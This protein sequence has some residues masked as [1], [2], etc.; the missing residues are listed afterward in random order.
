MK[1]VKNSH[2]LLRVSHCALY[3]GILM[4]YKLSELKI[5]PCTVV[6]ERTKDSENIFASECGQQFNNLNQRNTVWR[7]GKFERSISTRGNFVSLMT[8]F[9]HL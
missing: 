1:S 7:K 9:N 8:L 3:L 4:G 6:K 5:N 2:W